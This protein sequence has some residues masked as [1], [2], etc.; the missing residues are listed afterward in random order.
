MSSGTESGVRVGKRTSDPLLFAPP[1][2]H[3]GTRTSRAAAD[4]AT[5][6]AP[7]SRS[8]ILAHLDECWAGRTID[9]IA[10]ELQIC[11]DTVKARVHELG[12]TGQVVAL[13]E[14]GVSFAGSPALVFITP[15]NRM[16]RD[17]EAW[18]LPRKNWRQEADKQERRAIDAE[19]RVQQLEQ[20]L[21]ARQESAA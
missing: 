8:R 3:N 13:E 10:R 9:E 19:T 5:P 12:Q 7:T 20:Q 6:K 1:P 17:L 21:A 4:A 15:K 11:T 18:P 2:A 16:D 14:L